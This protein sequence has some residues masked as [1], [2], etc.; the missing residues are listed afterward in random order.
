Q[1]CPLAI[2]N[3]P[4]FF[5]PDAIQSTF[6]SEGEKI[7]HSDIHEHLKK[8]GVEKPFPQITRKSGP[9]RSI[10]FMHYFIQ[11][12]KQDFKNDSELMK[13]A[14]EAYRNL[15]HRLREQWG[16]AFQYVQQ[17]SA[18]SKQSKRK[19][20]INKSKISQRRIRLSRDPK[21]TRTRVTPIETSVHEA[22]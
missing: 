9:N 1:N 20:R 5:I 10:L 18:N 17:S 19:G 14:W 12:N 4:Y 6:T 13:A 15:S 2:M 7:L 3:P 11:K 21:S 22:D 8:L 16:I